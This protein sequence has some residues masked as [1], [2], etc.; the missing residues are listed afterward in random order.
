M[1]KFYESL[2]SELDAQLTRIHSENTCPIQ[3]AEQAISILVPLL[4]KLKTFFLRYSFQNKAEEIIFFREIKPKLASKLIYYNEIFNIATAKP[5]AS[6]KSIRKY[7]MGEIKKLESFFDDN[8]DFYK[9]YRTGNRYLDNKY[10]IR[11]KHDIRLTLDSFYLQADHRF[12]TSHDYK[13]ARILAND[14]IRQYLEN[15]IASLDKESKPQEV[16]PVKAI[17]WT[18]PKVALIELIYALHAEAVLDGGT[19]D[20]KEIVSHFETMF[21]I[22]LGQFHRVFLEIRA[23]KSDR[24]RFLNSITQT[25]IA[26]MDDADEN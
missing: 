18:G 12:S 25:L 7:Y 13:V 17:K 11:G 9:Y 20:L 10:F 14:R 26:R 22:N 15:E 24:T 5:F 3:Y 21:N 1:I 16:T 6:K 19:A 2:T 23:R 4:E 8:A